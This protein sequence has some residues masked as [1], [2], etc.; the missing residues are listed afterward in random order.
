LLLLLILWGTTRIFGVAQLRDDSCGVGILTV[1]KYK[2]R[3]RCQTTE[4]E[5]FLAIAFVAAVWGLI[6][7]L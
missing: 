2:G 3:A 6:N 4:P 1:W 5:L 7:S